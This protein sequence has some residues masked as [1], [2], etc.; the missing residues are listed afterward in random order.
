MYQLKPLIALS[1]GSYVPCGLGRAGR[2]YWSC[3]YTTSF[4]VGDKNPQVLREIPIRVLSCVL[5]ICCLGCGCSPLVSNSAPS[6]LDSYGVLGP[7]R[8]GST[9][10]IT[11]PITWGRHES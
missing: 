6:E 3:R 2:G 7:Y 9:R 4:H 1:Y 11:T 8:L 5:S 10:D